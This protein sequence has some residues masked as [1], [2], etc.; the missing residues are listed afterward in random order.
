MDYVAI[1]MS[2]NLSLV[3]QTLLCLIQMVS[4]LL[5][6]VCT[7][8]TRF[9]NSSVNAFPFAFFDIYKMIL[10]VCIRFI[11]NVLWHSICT[12]LMAVRMVA[13]AVG[14]TC[15]CCRI[16]GCDMNPHFWSIM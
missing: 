12:A 6:I 2:I 1:N 15:M 16:W 7:M 5:L 13:M 10:Y 4:V 14:V 8:C 3:T 9:T 11:G